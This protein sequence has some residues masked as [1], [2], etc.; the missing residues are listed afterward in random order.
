MWLK[1]SLFEDIYSRAELELLRNLDPE[2]V[3]IL[4]IQVLELRSLYPDF[5]NKYA[6]DQSQ[7]ET[8]YPRVRVIQKRQAHDRA[9]ILSVTLHSY[10]QTL[11]FR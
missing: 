6:H 11:G 7:T 8:G 5:Y 2:A 1:L 3:V 10:K 4:R 9:V